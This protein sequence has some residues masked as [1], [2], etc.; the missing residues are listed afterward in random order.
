LSLC[1]GC[2]GG[3]V[4]GN[5]SSRIGNV[6]VRVD[7]ATKRRRVGA[8]ERV[9]H[10]ERVLLLLLLL[11]LPLWRRREGRMAST[12]RTDGPSPRSWRHCCC[13]C[14]VCED[15]RRREDSARMAGARGWD[16]CG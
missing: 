1:L 7:G 16:G 4:V 6:S 15:I 10:N 2:L 9:L 12:W 8:I 11:L 5:S 3:L 13:Y 14:W